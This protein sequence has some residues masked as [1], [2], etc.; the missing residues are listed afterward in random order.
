MKFI[1]LFIACWLAVGCQEPKTKVVERQI[2]N[3]PINVPPPNVPNNPDFIGLDILEDSILLDLNTL[4]DVERLNARYLVSCGDYNQ[5]LR[6]Q[7]EVESATNK[8]INSISTESVLEN[9]KPIPPGNCLFRLD[10]RDYG[11]TRGEWAAIGK[12]LLLKFV[13]DSARGQQIQ[14][15]TQS[16]Q[17][18]VINSDFATTTLG[19]D[20]LTAENGLYYALIEQPFGLQ[21]FF[22]SIGAD[23]QAQADDEELLLG[24]FSQ[25]QIALGKSRAVQIAEADEFYVMTSYDSALDE[26][27]D[28]FVTPFTFEVAN[29][30]GLRRSNKIFDFS[31]QEHIYFLANGMMAYR[32]NGRGGNAEVVAPNNVVINTLAAQ[33]Q[34]DPTINIG[35]CSGCHFEPTIRFN[36]QLRRHIAS[37]SAFGA[38]EKELGE[39]F[40]DQISIE[41]TLRTINQEHQE[42]LNKLGVVGA[43]DPIHDKLIFPFRAEQNADQ[44][45]GH[46]LIPTDVCLQ[47]IRGSAQSSQIFGNLLNGGTVSLSILSQNFNQLVIDTQAFRDGSL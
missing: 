31:A 7:K 6:D 20:A 2:P 4:S 23:I 36:D 42:A 11:L 32:L 21:A 41:A 16:L 38:L 10:L 15:L 9:V 5:G 44:V 22:D 26:A 29:A 12:R 47:R 43:K 8:Q 18:Y 3:G 28:H 33:R 39:V 37:N 30:Q 17:P 24:G 40:Y 46:L 35:S 45:C 14:F 19:A 27:L 25:S 34:L 1:Y 13:S